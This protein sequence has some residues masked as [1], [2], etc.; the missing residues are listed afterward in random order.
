MT[1]YDKE[2][3]SE[4]SQKAKK[5]LKAAIQIELHARQAARFARENKSSRRQQ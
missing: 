2:E 1:L 5:A 3:A 4:L